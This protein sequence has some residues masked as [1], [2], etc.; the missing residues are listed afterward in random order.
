MVPNDFEDPGEFPSCAGHA[1]L[2]PLDFPAVSGKRD[3]RMGRIHSA[4]VDVLVSHRVISELAESLKPIPAAPVRALVRRL[5]AIFFERVVSPAGSSTEA[6]EELPRRWQTDA[7]CSREA[8]GQG[9]PRTAKA[10][11]ELRYGC[12]CPLSTAKIPRL[13]RPTQPL[14]SC[15]RFCTFGSTCPRGMTA[16]AKDEMLWRQ[17]PSQKARLCPERIDRRAGCPRAGS[18]GAARRR[19]QRFAAASRRAILLTGARRDRRAG[20]FPQ[21]E[22]GRAADASAPH[23]S[24]TIGLSGFAH[25]EDCGWKFAARADPTRGRISHSRVASGGNGTSSFSV[26]IAAV[27]GVAG[28]IASLESVAFGTR[29]H[30]RGTP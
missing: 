1:A 17:S 24:S 7:G 28:G 10:A 29:R 26:L 4:A 11:D 8:S 9:F 2:A 13:P 5:T 22:T 20:F 27:T 19:P 30:P 25:A 14:R 3:G 18:E 21:M 23:A 15:R 16:R 6:E 12:H